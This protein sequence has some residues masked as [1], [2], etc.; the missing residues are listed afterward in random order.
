MN[1]VESVLHNEHEVLN[2]LKNRLPIFHLSNIFFRDIQYGIQSYL[3]GRR[4]KVSYTTAEAIARQFVAQLEKKKTLRPVDRQTWVVDHVAFRKP[5]EKPSA[6][7]KST[8]VAA[9]A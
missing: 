9:V 6:A 7:G 5:M 1:A 4:H 2:H 3:K 8:G